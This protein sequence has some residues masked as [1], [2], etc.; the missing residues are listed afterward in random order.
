MWYAY[1]TTL[2]EVNRIKTR[3]NILSGGVRRCWEGSQDDEALSP[4]STLNTMAARR[5]KKT[6]NP[7]EAAEVRRSELSPERIWTRTRKDQ[8]VMRDVTNRAILCSWFMICF[9]L[10][11]VVVAR[12][13]KNSKNLVGVSC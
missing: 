4:R 13:R 9:R 12:R 8:R 1:G 11:I 5:P 3:K 2:I 10:V 7:V 6:A